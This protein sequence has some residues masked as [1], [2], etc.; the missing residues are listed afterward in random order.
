MITTYVPLI[1]VITPLVNAF[2]KLC[3]AMMVMRALQK[4]VTQ[5]LDVFT[6]ISHGNVMMAMRALTILAVTQQVVFI[7]I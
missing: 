5:L 1:I 3:A 7:P 2:M 6:P 4:V